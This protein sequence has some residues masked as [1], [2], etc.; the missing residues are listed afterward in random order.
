MN[1][2]Y[3]KRKILEDITNKDST[4]VSRNKKSRTNET[5]HMMPILSKPV[6]QPIIAIPSSMFLQNL[7]PGLAMLK[8]DLKT[9]K[10][11]FKDL[12][13]LCGGNNKAELVNFFLPILVC[14]LNLNNAFYVV[15][16]CNA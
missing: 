10:M 1:S 9:D 15:T 6:H 8:Y 2:H 4:I 14:F 7:H 3:G 5:L 11:S 12:Q 13:R 16:I